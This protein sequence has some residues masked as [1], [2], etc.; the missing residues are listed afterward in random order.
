MS[1]SINY[2]NY[3]DASEG[4][5]TGT[6]ASGIA[7]KPDRLE[8]PYYYYG[9]TRNQKKA[10]NLKPRP[11]LPSQ[12]AQLELKK[13]SSKLPSNPLFMLKRQADKG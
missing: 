13:K 5:S 9:S 2:Y 8:N 3:R 4:R 1:P 11:L 10:S 7:G 6:A 12:R